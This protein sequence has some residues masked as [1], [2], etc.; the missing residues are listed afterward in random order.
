MAQ[1]SPRKIATAIAITGLVQRPRIAGEFGPLNTES[2]L[3]RKERAVS[4]IARRKDTIEQ[5]KA[6]A[7]STHDVLRST[8]T[9]EIARLMLGQQADRRCRDGMKQFLPFTDAQATH[10]KTVEG[11]RI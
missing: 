8:Y 1:I 3:G 5:I 4:S 10:S 7:H 11:H 9:H 6:G 2:A